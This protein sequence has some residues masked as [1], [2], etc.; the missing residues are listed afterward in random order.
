[1]PAGFNYVDT[2]VKLIERQYRCPECK[3]GFLIFQSDE[4]VVTTWPPL[5]PHRC[6]K[7][8]YEVKLQGNT[9]PSFYIQDSNGERN[10]Y[11]TSKV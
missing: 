7:C 8:R 1:M 2:E 11:L 6:N 9:Y 5:Y 4:V 10:V 3:R